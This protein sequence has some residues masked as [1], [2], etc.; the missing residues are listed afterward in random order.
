MAF[1]N[2]FISIYVQI[3]IS[4]CIIMYMLQYSCLMNWNHP[5]LQ[6]RSLERIDLH[7]RRMATHFGDRALSDAG[8]RCWNSFPPVIRLANSV[9]SVKA[10]L[11]SHLFA[12]AL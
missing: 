6:L 5:E 4:I 11:K 9:D 8:P 10:Q 2:C 12:K 1:A 7:M 3:S